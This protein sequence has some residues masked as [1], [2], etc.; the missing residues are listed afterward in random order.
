M[1]GVLLAWLVGVAWQLNQAQLWP[2]WFYAVLLLVA[3][4]ALGLAAWWRRERLNAGAAFA[5]NEPWYVRFARLPQFLV[6]LALLAAGFAWAGWLACGRQLDI[7]CADLQRQDVQV[8]GVVDALPQLQSGRWRFA[9]RI[10]EAQ[11]GSQPVTLPPKVLLSW[12]FND[13]NKPETRQ[14]GPE[15]MPVIHVGE[16]W[17]FEVRLRAPHGQANPHGFDYELWLWEQGI[18]AVGYVR[19]SRGSPAPELL[20]TASGYGIERSRESV[21][22]A[23]RATVPDAH[24]AGL[25]AALTLGDQH[26]IARDD[27]QVIRA[28]GV[29][30]LVSIS[31]LHITM[32][33]WLAFGLVGWLWR[34]SIRLMLWQPAHIAA[35]VGG[36]LCALGYALFAG[37]GIPAQRTVLM[38]GVVVVLRLMGVRW[39]WHA[40]WL[41][42]A[43]MVVAFDPWAL[44]QAGFWLSFIAVGV[45]L[46]QERRAE[47]SALSKRERHVMQSHCPFWQRALRHIAHSIWQLLVV[48]WQISIALAPLTLLLFQQV[49]VIGLVANLFAIPWVTLVMVPFSLLGVLWHPLWHVAAWTAEVLM[50]VLQWLSHWTWAV[51]SA[52]VPPLPIAFAAV[53]GAIVLVL[54]FWRWRYRA[55]GLLAIMPALWWQPQRPAVGQFDV[56]ALDVGQGSSVLVR[57]ATHSLLYDTGPRYSED[58]DAG[59]ML[60]VPALRALG[61]QLN[62]VVV[63]HADTDHA[64]GLGSVLAVFPQ[65][66]VLLS[67]SPEEDL[68]QLPAGEKIPCVAGYS[69]QWDGVTFS[70]LYPFEVA[71]TETRIRARADRNAQSCVLRVTA[72][73]ARNGESPVSALLT[74][75]VTTVQEK[76]LVAHYA[77]RTQVNK[78]AEETSPQTLISGKEGGTLHAQWLLV[79]HHGSKSS[80]SALFL[81]AVKPQW[82]VVQAGYMNQF[83]HPVPEVLSRYAQYG[84]Q[85]ANTADCG[86]AR[87]HSARPETLTCERV[88]HRHYWQSP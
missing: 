27:W 76:A 54:P 14:S 79:P 12:Y 36:L 51:W 75:D 4:F 30:H 6:M 32:M 85:V 70:V 66:S 44:R 19:T 82:A 88:L 61:V 37:W 28:T 57:T 2:R 26:A 15:P 40:V 63:S 64:G 84:V 42:A 77:V 8:T 33:A 53:V 55:L 87:W 45:L 78:T 65:A 24:S 86:A 49:S 74:G 81:D 21:R 25:L 52:A 18:G 73:S 1:E 38:L 35:A 43:A 50:A 7:L 48:Q 13:N 34:R 11:R 46:A 71:G 68:W 20:G 39:P 17:A 67:A 10:D 72:Q 22:E 31:G 60:V 9:F 69:W 62:R 58:T 3:L 16:R 5:F 29:A 23:I 47:D 59:D 80:S 41:L 56:L 83:G